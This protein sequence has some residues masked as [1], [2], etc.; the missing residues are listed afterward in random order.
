MGRS[1]A[2]RFPSRIKFHAAPS[3][4]NIEVIHFQTIERER[5]LGVRARARALFASARH[6]SGGK[7]AGFPPAAPETSRPPSRE[8]TGIT[9]RR[10]FERAPLSIIFR[11]CL[12]VATSLAG[13]SIS[14]SLARFVAGSSALAVGARRRRDAAGTSFERARPDAPTGAAAVRSLARSRL[15]SCMSSRASRSLGGRS[16]GA[17]ERWASSCAGARR[18]RVENSVGNRYRSTS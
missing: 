12:S 15:A 6:S 9:E 7:D 1:F 5:S 2:S 4:F 13:V 16:R 3:A 11:G 14:S 17:R 10:R 18:R 8:D